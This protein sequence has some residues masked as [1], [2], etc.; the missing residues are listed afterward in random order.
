M[1]KE[2]YNVGEAL[3]LLKEGVILKDINKAKFI[4]R[5]DR[6]YVYSFNSSYSLDV[7]EF[8]VLYKENQ[9][10]IDSGDEEIIDSKKDEEYYNF[11][12]K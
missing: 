11:K 8:L 6:I 1:D 2:I 7:K 3:T 4:Y 12:H 9:F 10:V 5:K